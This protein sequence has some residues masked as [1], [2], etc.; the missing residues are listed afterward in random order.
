MKDRDA[1]QLR[2]LGLHAVQK[3]GVGGHGVVLILQLVEQPVLGV[4]VVG[5]QCI[6]FVLVFLLVGVEHRSVLV[7]VGLQVAAAGVG[8]IAVEA[9]DLDKALNLGIFPVQVRTLFFHCQAVELR[10]DGAVGRGGRLPRG[11]ASAHPEQQQIGGGQHGQQ[12]REQPVAPHLAQLGQKQAHFPSPS[13]NTFRY[14]SSSPP[15]GA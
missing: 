11:G 13:P 9:A 4:Q 7:A 10:A 1:R 3:I 8:H 15:P 6:A 5:E 2:R 12:K 14:T